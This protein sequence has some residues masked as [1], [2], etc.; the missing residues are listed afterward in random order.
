MSDAFPIFPD[1]A[2]FLRALHVNWADRLPRLVYADWLD[3]RS[4]P[5]GELLRVDVALADSPDDADLKARRTVVLTTVKDWFWMKLVG[6]DPPRNEWGVGTADVVTGRRPL[7]GWR[8]P[9]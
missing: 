4:D 2:P 5:R 7:G 3:E 8:S 1:D 9:R 6:C